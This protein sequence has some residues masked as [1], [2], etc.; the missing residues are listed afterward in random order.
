MSEVGDSIEYEMIVKNDSNE[1]YELDKTTLS[2]NSDYIEYTFDTNRDS[3][4]VKKGETKKV[5]LKV[6]YKNEVAPNLFQNG[7]YIDSKK[8]IVNLANDSNN[9]INNPNTGWIKSIYVLLLIII[10]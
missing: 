9:N 2:T 6:S 5:I 8:L 3:N 1:D 10:I 4:I 7:I